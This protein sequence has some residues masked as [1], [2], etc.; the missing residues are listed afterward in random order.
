MNLFLL[1]SCELLGRI[2][3]RL[4]VVHSETSHSEQSFS[5][6][7]QIKVYDADR[8]FLFVILALK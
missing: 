3:F 7:S 1:L 2:C 4:S 8:P 6:V 5:Q